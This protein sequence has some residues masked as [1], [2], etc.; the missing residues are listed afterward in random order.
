MNRNGGV[1]YAPAKASRRRFLL[2]AGGTVATG[3]VGC[4]EQPA[5]DAA[6]PAV[7]LARATYG[8]AKTMNDRILVA[9]AS[10]KGA[11]S[12][13]ADAI[14]KQ[15]AAGGATVD[16]RPVKEVT[17][18]D[19]Y[20]AAVIGS[21]IHSGQWLPEATTFLQANQ[22]RLRQMP[23]AIFGVCI[24]MAQKKPGQQQQ[25]ASW[26]DAPRGLVNPVAESVFAGALWMKDYPGLFEKVGMR[27]LLTVL[28]VAEGD[29]RDWDAIRAWADDNRPRLLK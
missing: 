13:V 27:I 11:T 17:E 5:A 1:G 12:G 25:L 23:T 19:A 3:V 26:L 15:L 24:T 18:L 8:E 2:L 29:H 10:E 14:G 20:R 9:Y 7:E 22:S 4:S 28:G 21:A 6:Q 16:V